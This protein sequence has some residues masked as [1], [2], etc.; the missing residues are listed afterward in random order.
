MDHLID[1]DAFERIRV[2]Y[3]CAEMYDGGDFSTYPQ[4]H[5]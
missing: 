5:G 1:F 3:L 4:R 2:P